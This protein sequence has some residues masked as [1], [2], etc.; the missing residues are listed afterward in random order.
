[1]PFD[2]KITE[3]PAAFNDICSNRREAGSSPATRTLKGVIAAPY[4]NEVWFNC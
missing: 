3:Y 1:M 4:V 2:A